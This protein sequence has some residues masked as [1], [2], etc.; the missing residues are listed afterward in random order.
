MV[1]FLVVEDDEAGSDAL[2]ECLE[3]IIG[4]GKVDVATDYQTALGHVRNTPYDLYIVDGE[5]FTDPS[6]REVRCV[7]LDLMKEIIRKEGSAEKIRH[8]TAND[9]LIPKAEALGVTK[10][11]RKGTPSG[12]YPK[13]LDILGEIRTEF[14][15]GK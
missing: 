15:A 7:G 1:R 10:I 11:Y 6:C 4:E 2:K 12:E 5:F 14:G 13:L 9:G 8:M 3:R